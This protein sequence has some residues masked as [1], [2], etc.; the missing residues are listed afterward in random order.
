LSGCNSI[1]D[2]DWVRNRE[3]YLCLLSTRLM[4]RGGS[5]FDLDGPLPEIPESNTRRAAASGSSSAPAATI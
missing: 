5:Q 2:F 4:V 1:S 3:D